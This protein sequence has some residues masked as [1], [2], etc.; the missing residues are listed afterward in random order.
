MT[1]GKKIKIKVILAATLLLACLSS[2]FMIASGVKAADPAG[3]HFTVYQ[4]DLMTGA[5]GTPATIFSDAAG[6]TIDIVGNPEVFGQGVVPV[7]T[8]KRIKFSVK[9]LVDFSGPNPCTGGT[10]T[11]STTYKNDAG[12][13]DD[14]QVAL[15]FATSDDGGSSE[16]TA[17]GSVSAPYLIQNP[18]RIEANGDYVVKLIFNTAGTLVCYTGNMPKV[19]GPSMNALYYANVAPATAGYCS[20][21]GDYWFFNYRV[22]SYP[23]DAS[24]N[25]IANPTLAQI[26]QSGNVISGWGSMTFSPP[27]ATTG[28]GTWTMNQSLAYANGGTAEHR[29]NLYQYSTTATD[30]GY[31]DPS[32]AGGAASAPYLFKG[33]K[34]LITFPDQFTINGAMSTDC[35][36]F[37]GVNLDSREGSN[38]IVAIKKPTSAPASL[39]V[40]AKYI[41]VGPE[42]N[43]TFDAANNGIAGHFGYDSHWAAF[44]TGSTATAADG[45]FMEWKNR[46]EMSPDFA[47]TGTWAIS[48]PK[49]QTSMTSNQSF[50]NAFIMRSDGLVTRELGTTVP[51]DFGAM[52]ASGNGIK[53]GEPRDTSI[54]FPGNH[55]MDA[56]YFAQ[57]HPSPTLN[58]IAGT[59]SI[60][61]L[62]ARLNGANSWGTGVSFGEITITYDGSST[63]AQACGGF[64]YRDNFSS[65]IDPPKPGCGTIELHTECYSYNN[66]SNTGQPVTTA[67]TSCT[68][69]TMPVFYFMKNGVAD[70]KF[71]L[72]NNKNTIVVWSPFDADGTPC[73]SAKAGCTP[74]PLSNTSAGIGVKTQ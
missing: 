48:P 51:E 26:M 64:T 45:M 70:A 39:A 68:G 33:N 66:A 61:T 1:D 30:Q 57:V 20:T 59:W 4:T 12:Q 58:D 13:S 27:N 3:V 16:W 42:V 38:L 7:G 44:Y 22:S 11:V 24:G 53:A 10:T 55:R 52:G 19:T 74:D 34:M 37:V 32:L 69:I 67:S 63:S 35:S 21:M 36:T 41:S 28:A 65:K 46:F 62:E 47:G 71:V 6:K 56:G 9:N 14:A 50:V 40:N 43:M 73:S 49:E 15:Y 72:D 25:L 60:G 17:N 31:F 18:I 8:Y 23:A 5:T 29:H 2:V 54:S